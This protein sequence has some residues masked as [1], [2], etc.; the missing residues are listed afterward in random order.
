VSELLLRI[1]ESH[2]ST[3]AF[4]VAQRILDIERQM[5]VYPD[6]M[7]EAGQAKMR[8]DYLSQLK[9]C[10]AALS[11]RPGVIRGPAS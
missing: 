11:S 6:A 9:D 10:L 5:R 4:V 8:A 7:V 2:L 1:D 3:A